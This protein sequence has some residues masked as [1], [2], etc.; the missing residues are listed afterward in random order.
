MNDDATY[1]LKLA[2]TYVV[3]RIGLSLSGSYQHYSGYPFQPQAS[4]ALAQGSETINLLPAGVVRL[5]DRDSLNLRFSRPFTLHER[6]RLEPIIDVFNITNS[7][8]IINKLNFYGTITG[9]TFAPFSDY[10]LPTDM[11]NP[12]V[13]RIGF[14]F[15]F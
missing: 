3:P 14:K 10:E 8:S 13:L 9:S 2:S 15:D 12:R 6:F 4:V 5:P 11:L 1:A 7:G